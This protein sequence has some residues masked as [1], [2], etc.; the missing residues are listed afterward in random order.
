MPLPGQLSASRSNGPRDD[1]PMR[2]KGGQVF[3]VLGGL[4]KSTPLP[5][6]FYCRFLT[7]EL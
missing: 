3:R 7:V 2:S 6:V 1:G 5:Y 4:A